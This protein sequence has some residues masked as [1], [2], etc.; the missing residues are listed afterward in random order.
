M[1]VGERR[2][3]LEVRRGGKEKIKN[4]VRRERKEDGRMKRGRSEDRER[5]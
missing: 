2:E 1:M 5:Y 3:K 4:D